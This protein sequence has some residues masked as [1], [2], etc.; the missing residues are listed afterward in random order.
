[1]QVTRT[2]GASYLVIRFLFLIGL[3]VHFVTPIVCSFQLPA[4]LC[5]N[6]QQSVTIYIAL[7]LTHI[8]NLS[9]EKSVWPEA[10]KSAEIISIYKAGNKSNI[11]NY[12]PISLMGIFTELLTFDI[13]IIKKK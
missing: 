9:I 10:F 12:R 2:P 5:P 13:S 3:N 11:T 1:M 6:A 4:N 7:P 8:L